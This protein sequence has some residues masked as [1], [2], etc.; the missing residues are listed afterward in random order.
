MKIKVRENVE[1]VFGDINCGEVFY[2]G[3][4]YYMKTTELD[5]INTVCLND[6]CLM[7]FQYYDTV[8]LVDAILEVR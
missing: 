8:E 7:L 3:T 6:G 4:E 1:T 2:Y 5:N